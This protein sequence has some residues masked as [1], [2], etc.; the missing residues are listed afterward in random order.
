M[1]P[2]FTSSFW[3]YS[4]TILGA[5]PRCPDF[6]VQGHLQHCQQEIL[7]ILA[8]EPRQNQPSPILT[9]FIPLFLHISTVRYCNHCQCMSVYPILWPPP[10]ARA[11]LLPRNMFSLL[12]LL[13][14]L[15]NHWCRFPFPLPP[16]Q[17]GTGHLRICF[18][19]FWN[20]LRCIEMFWICMHR[21]A[22]LELINCS[23]DTGNERHDA[24]M[25][26]H[27]RQ[28]DHTEKLSFRTRN[29]KRKTREDDAKQ[30]I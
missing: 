12:L 29:R 27:L 21:H 22:L 18:E 15:W 2:S 14:K 16:W 11:D 28:Q 26:G 20:V 4:R 1:N 10:T 7:L 3:F 5:H 24:M 17:E 6:A 30:F 23:W 19:L 13:G 8:Q 25:A 9:I